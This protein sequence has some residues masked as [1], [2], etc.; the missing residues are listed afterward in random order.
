MNFCV[1]DIFFKSPYR[2]FEITEIFIGRGKGGEEI[3]ELYKKYLFIVDLKNNK[4]KIHVIFA[5]NCWEI[6][7]NK[8]HFT[9][10]VP[11]LAVLKVETLTA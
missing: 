4:I 7:F 3:S 6:T 9:N 10:I 1:F 5:H 2:F 11:Y 8:S